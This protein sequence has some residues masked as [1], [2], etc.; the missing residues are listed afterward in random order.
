MDR[1]C[2]NP[3]ALHFPLHG[4]QLWLVCFVLLVFVV[5]PLRVAIGEGAFAD[6]LCQSVSWSREM[7]TTF[8][9]LVL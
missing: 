7:S 1:R 3:S 8:E 6:I 5:V 2:D 4:W 9:C